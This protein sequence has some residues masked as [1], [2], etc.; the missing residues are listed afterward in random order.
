MLINVLVLGSLIL[1]LVLVLGLWV[2]VNITAYT[3]SAVE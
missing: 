1:F 3:Y 2:L